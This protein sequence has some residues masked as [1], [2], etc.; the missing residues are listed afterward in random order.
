MSFHF[1]PEVAC[2]KSNAHWE[3]TYPDEEQC[4]YLENDKTH[5]LFEYDKQ[6]LRLGVIVKIV[7]TV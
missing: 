4:K 1:K 3:C 5:Q 7:H 2:N 6:N